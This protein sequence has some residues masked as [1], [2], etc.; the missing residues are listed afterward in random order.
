MMKN[1]YGIDDSIVML[2]NK[3][4]EKILSYYKEINCIREH[5]Q[6]K[7]TH[8][9]QK[10]RISERHFQV[11]TGYGYD[12]EGREGVEQVYSLVFNSEDAL[13]RPQITSGTHAISLCLYGV[14]RPGDEMI[15][16]TGNPYDTIKTIIGSD[17]SD[18]DLGT[19]YDY[20]ITYNQIE[21]L[22]GKIDTK[23]I[24]QSLNPKTKMIYIQRSTGYEWRKA[25]SIQ[26]IKVFIN[27]I[28]KI[29]KKIIVMVDNCYGEFMDYCEP[30]DVGAD[31][32][33]GSLIKNP[34][35]GLAPVGGY[36]VGKKEL[37]YKAACRLSAPGIAK[38]TGATLGINRT[39]L[40][41]L[42]L[43]PH[44]V[45]E[46]IKTA[47]LAARIFEDLGFE[48]CPKSDDY[49]SDIIQGIKFQDPKAVMDFC[50]GIQ[51]A[52]PVDSF[53][54]PEPWDM[55]GY[56]SKIIMAAGSFIQGSSIELSAD[57][58]MR[59]PYIAYLQGGLTHDHGKLGIYI[60]L[61]ELKNTEF[62]NLD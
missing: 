46:A 44:V 58:P 26:E 17:K 51:K 15:S 55:P 24:E 12:D 53:L 4:E 13:V 1:A 20:G 27:Y 3:N 60:A 16:V 32:I 14:L 49:R 56:D 9:M 21:L 25:L 61:Q 8:A 11:S 30:T 6:I 42:F 5:N 37:V 35:G 54:V 36:I 59:E 34:G 38:E 18:K 19:L 47:I 52:A 45:S 43:A 10:A 7:V 48:V 33:A 62:I 28:K 31:L 50:K 57:A 23:K 22:N 2:C 39:Y 41:G 29:N 40:Q